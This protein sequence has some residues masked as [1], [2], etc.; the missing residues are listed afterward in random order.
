MSVR[1]KGAE[2]QARTGSANAAVTCWQ[3]EQYINGEFR[4]FIVSFD[5]LGDLPFVSGICARAVV[6]QGLWARE[7][8]VGRWGRD[9][10]ALRR[11]LTCEAR[12]GAGHCVV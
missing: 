4:I 6:G 9:D 10:V 12:H 1:V 2:W 11:D 3:I 7:F 8:V 5:F